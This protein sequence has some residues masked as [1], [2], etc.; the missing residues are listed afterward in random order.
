MK[1]RKLEADRNGRPGR[2]RRRKP[3]WPLYM[4]NVLLLIFAAVQVTRAVR[5]E[6]PEPQTQIE[7]FRD[8]REDNQA[9]VIQG[10]DDSYMAA[11]LLF[12]AWDE[13]G[14]G[15]TRIVFFVN[16]NGF[17]TYFE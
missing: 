13:L 3:F 7:T 8:S 1:E 12:D 9:P 15:E 14:L 16:R 17:Y 2:S 11:Q 5:A 6:E 10:A 4:L